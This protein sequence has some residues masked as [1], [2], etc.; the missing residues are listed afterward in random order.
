MLQQTVI[1]AVMPVYARFLA[2]FPDVRALAAADEDSVREAVRGLG[3]YRRFRFLHLAAKELVAS[4]PGSEIAWPTD[5]DGW[6][7][8]PGVGDYT[9]AAVSSIA[10]NVAAA[11]VDGNVERVFCR[12]F[13]LRE[14]PNSA[15][16]KK[17]FKVVAAELLDQRCPGAANQA[18]MEL[19]QLICTPTAPACD[20]CPVSWACAAK[21]AKSQHLAPGPKAKP[22]V[23]AV[24]LQLVL[25]RHGQHFAL[26]E[27]PM[28]ARFLKGT[29]G[30]PTIR[31]HDDGWRGDGWAT[32]EV[33]AGV[34]VGSIKHTITHH[35][36]TADVV[37][38][39]LPTKKTP[40]SDAGVKWQWCESEALEP[41]LTSNLDR[42]AWDLLQRVHLTALHSP[43][44]PSPVHLHKSPTRQV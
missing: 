41:K 9:A 39:D 11:V 10:F 22:V 15:H 34:Q 3:Y 33:T 14:A 7:A 25:F 19:G 31:R 43:R 8:L 38:I 29:W 21:K 20:A 28:A 4:S 35:K 2:R 44:Q 37:V 36:L 26:A 13:D 30:W 27:R 5:F 18:L 6:R 12:L 42:K 17:V 16:L 32:P 1:K 40:A 24:H 23:L